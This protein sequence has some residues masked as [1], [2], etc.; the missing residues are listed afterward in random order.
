VLALDTL[1]HWNS[2]GGSL[3]GHD[4]P[5]ARMSV[6]FRIG[7]GEDVGEPLDWDGE[8][9]LNVSLVDAGRATGLTRSELQAHFREWMKVVGPTIMTDMF[10]QY[11]ERLASEF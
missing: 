11:C 10:A 9:E 6:T 7:D 3:L 4:E 5:N 1:R 8:I 2:T